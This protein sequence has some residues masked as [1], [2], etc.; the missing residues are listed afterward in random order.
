MT[1]AHEIM[2]KDVATLNP[3]TSVKDAAKLFAKKG[4]GGAP[5]ID[6]NGNLVGIVSESDLIMRDVKA[7][8]PHY[9]ALLDSVIFLGGLHQ[10]EEQVKKAVGATVGQVMTTEVVTVTEDAS[11]EE[12]AQLMME[13]HI[14]RLPV[15]KDNK[16]RGIITKRN[17][18]A[19]IGSAK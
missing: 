12:V 16:I 4:I 19:T 18:V 11:I 10:Y 5:V 3:E 1:K 17:I 7:H 9:I 6:E 8:F 13:K 14:S 15:V 2:T